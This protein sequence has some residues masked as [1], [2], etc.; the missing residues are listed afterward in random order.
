MAGKTLKTEAIVLR[1]IRYGEA[2]RILHLYTAKRG[3]VGAIAKGARRP[4]SRF[5]GRLEPAPTLLADEAQTD[6]AALVARRRQLQEMLVMERNRLQQAAGAV[7]GRIETHIGWLEQELEA[8]EA[9]LM[10]RV[11]LHLVGDR[12]RRVHRS[13]LDAL[14][15]RRAKV[16]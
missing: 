13:H 9:E 5:G 16:G 10:R 1:S 2:D 4:K 7:R 12:T 8:V 3:R 14:G 15:I 11:D 6:F